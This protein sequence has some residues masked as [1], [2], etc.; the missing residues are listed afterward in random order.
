MKKRYIFCLLALGFP[1]RLAR[2]YLGFESTEFSLFSWT[3][4]PIFSKVSGEIDP[5]PKSSNQP[6]A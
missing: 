1:G 6:I 2:Y 4:E 3:E 5:A